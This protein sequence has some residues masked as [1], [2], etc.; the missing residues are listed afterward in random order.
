MFLLEHACCMVDGVCW[1]VIGGGVG[2]VFQNRKTFRNIT[3]AAWL[4]GRGS[5]MIRYHKVCSK[6]PEKKI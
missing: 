6:V 3:K 5:S 4:L 1:L 2:G